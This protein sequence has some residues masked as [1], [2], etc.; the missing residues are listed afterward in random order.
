MN[1]L[2]DV[3]LIDDHTLLRDSMCRLLRSDGDFGRVEAAANAQEGLDVFYRFAADIVLLDIDMPGLNCFDAAERMMSHRP[4]T[5]I[6][7]LS[8]FVL[9]HYIEQ[10]LRIKAR[11]YLCKSEPL[12]SVVA[13]IKRVASGK[14]YFSDEVRSRIVADVK[15]ARLGRPARVRV[16][17][18]TQREIEVV[19][20]LARGMSKKQIASTMHLSLKTVEGHAERL[21]VKLGIHDRVELA[22][23][24]IR[25][26][27]ATV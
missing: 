16:S 5:P 12:V 7:F 26:G 3:L 24:A 27:L 13:A 22:R 21:M 2:I 6:L 25:E 20:Y 4:Q 18:L 11:G 10:A 17:T 19:A 9:D 15:G 1:D 8:A 14:M 23:F